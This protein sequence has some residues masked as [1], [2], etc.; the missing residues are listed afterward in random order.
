MR[1]FK[2]TAGFHWAFLIL[3]WVGVSHECFDDYRLHKSEQM[4]RNCTYL[5]PITR[6]AY[7]AT[8]KHFTHF[9]DSPLRLCLYSEFPPTQIHNGTN[10]DCFLKNRYDVATLWKMKVTYNFPQQF[11]IFVYL[12]EICVIAYHK[13]P[14]MPT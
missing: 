14:P 8:V 3:N 11:Y 7:L 1:S 10:Y 12:Q 2:L 9:I 5:L 4:I 6:S 13:T